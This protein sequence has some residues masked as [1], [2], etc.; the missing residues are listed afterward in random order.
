MNPGAERRR[1]RWCRQRTQYHTR[2]Q[3]SKG[4]KAIYYILWGKCVCGV[5][6]R[7]GTIY[8]VIRLSKLGKRNVS[9]DQKHREGEERKTCG[10]PHRRP[11]ETTILFSV[12]GRW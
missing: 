1:R 6:V 2:H 10:N 8:R 3:I 11:I 5:H 9:F 7:V 4:A 12:P